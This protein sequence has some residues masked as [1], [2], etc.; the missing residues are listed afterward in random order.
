MKSR[1]LYLSGAITNN[2]NYK[3]DFEKAYK[4]LTD[5]GYTVVSPLAIC[6]DGWDWD[7]C[8]WHCIKAL[9]TRCDS[10]AVIPSDYKSVGTKIEI[11]I[12]KC[13]GMP[14][15]TVE[16]WIKEGKENG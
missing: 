4:D 5:A 3:R 14:V 1:V 2:P 10:V 9:I 16:G 8:M 11:H 7:T 12:A 13:L 6:D 15:K